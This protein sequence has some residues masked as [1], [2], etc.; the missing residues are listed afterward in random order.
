MAIYLDDWSSGT[1]IVGNLCVQ[2]GRAILIGGGRDNLV[3]NNMSVDCVPAVHIDSRGLGWA[4]NYFDGQTT[5]LMDRL[6]A[7]NYL[8]P[9]Y[10]ER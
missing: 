1:T 2:A 10:S 6:Q 4:K 9:P 7:M 8:H 5:T 3:Q